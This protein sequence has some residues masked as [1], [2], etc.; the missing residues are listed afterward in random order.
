M[1]HAIVLDG[2]PFDRLAFQQNGL[3]TSGVDVD[4]HEVLQALMVAVAIAVAD[5]VVDLNLKIARQEVVLKQR[6]GSLAFDASARSCLAS[7]D[8]LARRE[9]GRCPDPRAIR[10]N[11]RRC[12]TSHCPRAGA[13]YALLTA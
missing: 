3:S 12:R 9:H 10:L 7:A 6:C 8:G 4:G 2:P 1:L 5:E 11:R 13:A